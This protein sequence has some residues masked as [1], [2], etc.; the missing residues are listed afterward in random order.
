MVELSDGVVRLAPPVEADIPAI[1]AACQDPQISRWTTVPIPYTREHGEAFVNEM[2]ADG[3]RAWF[4]G[5]EAAKAIWA[6]HTDDGFAGMLGLHFEPVRS[7]DVGFWVA[8]PARGKGLLHRGMLLALQW[9]FDAPDGP[10]LDRVA[11]RALAGNWPSWRAAW[12]VGF[13]FTGVD[14]LGGVQHDF[15]RDQWMATLLRDEPRRPVAE[16]PATS[17]VGPRPSHPMD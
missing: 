8:A 13:Q 12:K 5:G 2:V 17:V 11:W 7:A 9:A 10:H 6:L 15:R 3:W 1:T 4:E 16:W 14:R